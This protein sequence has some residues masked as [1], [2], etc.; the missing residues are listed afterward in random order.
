MAFTT[1][2][3]DL[4]LWDAA[5][6]QFQPG[7]LFM[8]ITRS[9]YDALGNEGRD[10]FRA[11]LSTQLQRP[12]HFVVNDGCVY[13]DN[14]HN[15]Q[16]HFARNAEAEHRLITSG[17]ES[18]ATSRPTSRPFHLVP[19]PPRFGAHVE[20]NSSPTQTQTFRGT[21]APSSFGSGTST[22]P[23]PIAETAET[24][25]LAQDDYAGLELHCM[26]YVFLSGSDH[27]DFSFLLKLRTCVIKHHTAYKPSSHHVRSLSAIR[28]V[29]CSSGLLVSP[30]SSQLT[31]PVFRIEQ[32]IPGGDHQQATNLANMQINHGDYMS[33]CSNVLTDVSRK[34]PGHTTLGEAV[35]IPV[36]ATD[37]ERD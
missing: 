28:A 12:V 19:Q 36:G 5:S 15:I 30:G 1:Q 17:T 7:H 8:V 14:Q 31:I 3:I 9:V 37:G 10:L 23:A 22:C 34:I 29:T 27:G 2:D 35:P 24:S 32:G 11:N 26:Y 21:Q 33:Y 20:M 4:M 6:G 13:I 16:R 18:L 25:Q